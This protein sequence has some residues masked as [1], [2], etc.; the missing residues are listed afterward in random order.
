MSHSDSAGAVLS[1]SASAIGI[2]STGITLN[3]VVLAV[4][5]A[6][7]LLRAP[8]D[9]RNLHQKVIKPWWEGRGK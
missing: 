7:L 5:L 3:D 4:T 6:V 8:V 9:A 1:Y 2:A